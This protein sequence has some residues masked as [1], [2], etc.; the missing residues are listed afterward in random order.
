MIRTHVLALTIVLAP[1]VPVAADSPPG[2]GSASGKYCNATANAAFGA[3]EHQV[4]DDYLVSF[5]KCINVS[6]EDARNACFDDAKSTRLDE[7]RGC[8]D[9]RDARR[10]VCH[11]L[12]QERYVF[13][14]DAALFDSDFS[15]LTN[16]NPYFPLDIGNHWEYGGSESVTIEVLPKTKL[17]EG[18]TCIVVNDR[19]TVNGD[20]VEDTDDWFGQAKNGD[21]AYCGEEVKD[22]ESFPGDNPQEAELVS[23]DGSFKAGRDGDQ[24]G[25]AFRASPTPGQ[26]YRQ[27]FS[28]ANAEDVA[29]ILSVN[30]SFGV[31]TDL[32]QF[33]PAALAQLLCADDCIVVKEFTPLSPDAVERKYYAL[34]I[35]FFFGVNL[36]TGEG[37]QLVD[38]NFDSRCSTLPSP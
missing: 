20:V 10:D 8:K 33:V 16:P 28:L 22:Y 13:D 11:A 3:C 14:F 38:C 30:Y 32:D 24:P 1:A 6:D 37:V 36:E 19:V 27:E 4:R 31:D 21:V 35:G 5:G 7:L 12:G 2:D 34:G 9:Q 15:S 29:E 17:I 26:V 25:F 23:I 18:V